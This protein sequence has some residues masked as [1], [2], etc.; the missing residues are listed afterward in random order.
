MLNY[1]V[2]RCNFYQVK[3]QIYPTTS[4][5]PSESSTDILVYDSKYVV[6]RSLSCSEVSYFQA[7]FLNLLTDWQFYELL[8]WKIK[9]VIL[10]RHKS[11]QKQ[12]AR[13]VTNDL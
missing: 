2:I 12:L 10:G 9:Q 13:N 1:N 5:E 8:R 7:V 6:I 4:T 11:N 3:V